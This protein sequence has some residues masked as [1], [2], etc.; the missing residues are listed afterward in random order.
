MLMPISASCASCFFLDASVTC[1][2]GADGVGP[3]PN[4]EVEELA[5]ELGPPPD[6]KPFSRST[7]IF[8]R[9]LSF[10]SFSWPR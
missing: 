8:E 9:S 1:G 4:A 5:A 2:L 7:S 3:L 6:T 10:S